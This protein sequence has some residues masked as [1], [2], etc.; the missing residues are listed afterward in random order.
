MLSVFPSLLSWGELSP[1]LIRLTLGLVFIFWGYQ[2]L[3]R[4][5]FKREKTIG[6][7]EG[8]VGILL[9]IGL[10]TQIAT[11]LAALYL[12]FLLGDKLS[13]KALLTSGINYYLILFVLAIS[14]LFTGAGFFAFDY[15]L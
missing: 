14:L 6:I 1:F 5:G 11:L 10:W 3:K 13:K 9:I 12:A 8:L 4:S 7:I 15:P 2:A